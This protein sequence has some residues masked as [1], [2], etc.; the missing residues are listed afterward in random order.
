VDPGTWARPRLLAP[1][2]TRAPH[3][4]PWVRTWGSAPATPLGTEDITVRPVYLVKLRSAQLCPALAV[5]L[6]DAAQKHGCIFCRSPFLQS[7]NTF[8]TPLGSR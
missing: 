6:N 3:M 7:I 2:R 8:Q 4:R 5:K 1:C